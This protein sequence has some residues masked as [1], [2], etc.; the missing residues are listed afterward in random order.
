MH[1]AMKAAAGEREIPAQQ[2]TSSGRAAAILRHR[3]RKAS[4]SR[5]WRVSGGV[6]P[7]RRPEMSWNVNRS[8]RVSGMDRSG[9]AMSG[10]RSPQTKASGCSAVTSVT[11]SSGE[12]MIMPPFSH[13]AVMLSSHAEGAGVG[14]EKTAPGA[15]PGAVERHAVC[16]IRAFP[17]D[18]KPMPPMSGAAGAAGCSFFGASAIMA[19]V[20]ISRPDTE[21][22]SS[23]AVRTTLAGSMIPIL[24]MSP[25]SP[26]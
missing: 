5:T 12:I 7:S 16:G 2:W 11:V 9:C 10:P 26:V 4:S 1:A 24:I 23:R 21:E 3:S 20:V 19:S 25:Y 15:N 13:S 22:E 17:C 18:Q 8:R 14:K 6:M